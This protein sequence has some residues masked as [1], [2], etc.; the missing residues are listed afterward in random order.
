MSG[1]ECYIEFE[2]HLLQLSCIV[3]YCIVDLCFGF[4]YLIYSVVFILLCRALALF[5]AL[6]YCAMQPVLQTVFVQHLQT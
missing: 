1:S 2:V 3:C 5:L 6:S 4:A